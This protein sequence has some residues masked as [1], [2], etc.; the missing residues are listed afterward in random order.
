MGYQQL[1]WCDQFLKL[2]AFLER[3]PYL[4]DL[5]RHLQARAPIEDPDVLCACTEC[6]ASRIQ[7]GTAATHNGHIPRERGARVQVELLEKARRGSDAL[8]DQFSH[9]A[10][11][12]AALGPDG[13]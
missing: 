9:H 7:R 3:S 11:G 13:Q 4:L 12:L 6:R 5:R 8:P 2:N 10:R 1:E